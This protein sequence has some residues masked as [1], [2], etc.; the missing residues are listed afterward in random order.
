LRNAHGL[1][2]FPQEDLA[3]CDGWAQC[4][5]EIPNSLK[6]RYQGYKRCSQ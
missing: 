3:G 5:N 4:H 6:I 1:K 2:V